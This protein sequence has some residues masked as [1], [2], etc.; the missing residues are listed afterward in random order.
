MEIPRIAGRLTRPRVAAVALAVFCAAVLHLCV[1]GGFER[2]RFRVVQAPRMAEP[3][4]VTTRLPD[5]SALAGQPAALILRIVNGAPTARVVRV[6]AGDSIDEV[7]VPP[8]RERRVDLGFPD[9]GALSGRD[10]V[11]TGDG[12]GWSLAALEVANVH[13]FSNGLF[14]FV[15]APSGAGRAVR[16]GM[17]PA[18]A[19]LAVLLALTA[20]RGRAI[21]SSLA[22]RIHRAGAALSLA[23]LA[24]AL[25]APLVSDFAV[26]IAPHTFLVC[27]VVVYYPALRREGGYHLLY[28]AAAVMFVLFIAR[29]HEP[30]AGLTSLIRFGDAFEPRVL[31]SVRAVPR[32]V[33]TDATGY[34]GQF[35]VQLAVDPLL[36]DPGIEAALDV[37]LYRARRILFS[38]TAHL[39]GLGQPRWILQ[40]YVVQYVVLWLVLAWVLCRWFPP[41]SFRNL[42]GWCACMFSY[43]MVISVLWTVPDAPGMLLL[44]LGVLAME[45][46]RARPAA[47][48]VGVAG[49]AKETSLLWGAILLVPGGLKHE[50]WRERCFLGL[51]VVGP[52]TAWML[53]LLAG[54]L[55]GRSAGVG[56]LGVPLA[57]YLQRWQAVLAGLRDPAASPGAQAAAVTLVGLTTQAAVLLRTRQWTNAWWRAGMASVV[58]MVFLGPSV[59]EGYP[60]AAPRVLLPMT[61]AF[62]AV[63]PRNAWFWPLFVLGNL[64]VSNGLDML[65]APL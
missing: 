9:G 65:H 7:S 12:D 39:L 38:W 25:A 62:N 54:D 14:E 20:S 10:V 51:L 31:P 29:L 23:F 56:N 61:F 58:L 57:G 24:A 19:V 42:C 53:Y 30:G 60:G 13:G 47:G 63:L 17:P 44:A 2:Q 11:L 37:P 4:G 1:Y 16:V 64:P 46:G 27:L 32:H 52:L 45:R 3:G 41:T 33:L 49:L 35:Y 43:G 55:G 34:D 18:L 21:A 40:A 8:H 6:A 50:G 26:L 5:L 15:V 48:M 28:A 36:R 59:W 22:R